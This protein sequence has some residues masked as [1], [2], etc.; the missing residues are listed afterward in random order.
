MGISFAIPI[1]EARNVADQLRTSGRV[2]RGRIGVA[3]DQVTKEVA[4]SIGLGK[5]R[6]RA[7][8]QRG[9]GRAGRKGWCRSRATSSRKFDGR[10]IEKSGDLPRIVGGVKPGTKVGM[11]VFRRGA[12]K[13]LT[14]TV[15][16]FEPEVAQRSPEREVKPQPTVETSWAS[17]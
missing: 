3:I 14:V 7:G 5:P 15:A 6:R 17:A 4:E 9:F 11:Q 2:V 1:D 13:D 8:S 10:V 12:Y 16:E